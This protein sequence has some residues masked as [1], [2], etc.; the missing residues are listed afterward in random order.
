MKNGRNKQVE[1]IVE[2]VMEE[3]QKRTESGR[4]TAGDAADSAGKAAGDAIKSAGKAYKAASGAV[5]DAE[6][7]DKVEKILEFI[8]ENTSV[9]AQVGKK[10]AGDA[11]KEAP[12]AAAAVGEAVSNAA[13]AGAE[14]VNDALETLGKEVFRPTVRYGRGLRHGLLLG[15]V[16]AMLYTPWPGKVLREKL[17]AFGREAMDLVD[18]MRAGAADS[19]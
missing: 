2:T 12:A 8:E 1:A 15:A 7:A 14:A 9:V 4:D 10:L 5:K 11:V 19:A 16:I 13:E 3:L 6:I 18:A 17:T